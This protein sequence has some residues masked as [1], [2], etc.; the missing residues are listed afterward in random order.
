MMK[1]RTVTLAVV[2]LL[3][4]SFLASR[5]VAEVGGETMDGGKAMQ[6]GKTM[7]GDKK[8]GGDKGMRGGKGIEGDKALE[9]RKKGGKGMKMEG[10]DK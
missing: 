10:M 9:G 6:E 2:T 1:Y 4:V 7:Q 8:M 3:S 5:V